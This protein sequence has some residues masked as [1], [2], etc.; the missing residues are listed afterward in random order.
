MEKEMRELA[1]QITVTRWKMN[2][3]L[4][5]AENLKEHLKELEK[6]LEEMNNEKQS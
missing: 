6:K 1:N 3:H 5:V 2:K 4:K